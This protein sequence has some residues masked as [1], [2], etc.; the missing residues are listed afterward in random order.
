FVSL[1]KY[2]L[3]VYQRLSRFVREPL[4]FVWYP[5]PFVKFGLQETVLAVP[6]RPFVSLFRN[7]VSYCYHNRGNDKEFFLHVHNNDNASFSCPCVGFMKYHS[8]D[9]AK[10]S[11]SHDTSKKKSNHADSIIKRLFLFIQTIGNLFF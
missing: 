4:F 7:S 6:P 11:H 9:I 2:R 5:H 8:W 10:H 1:I 3:F